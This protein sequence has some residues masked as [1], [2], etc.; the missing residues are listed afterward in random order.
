MLVSDLYGCGHTRGC[1][2][3]AERRRDPPGF[4]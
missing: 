1:A 3:A 2:R 4:E